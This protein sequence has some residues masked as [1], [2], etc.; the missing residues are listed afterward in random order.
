MLHNAFGGGLRSSPEISAL[1][2][3]ERGGVLLQQQSYGTIF[4]VH[5][6]ASAKIQ[7]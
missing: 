2:S 6:L 7:V 1:M 4:E 3:Q 5:P